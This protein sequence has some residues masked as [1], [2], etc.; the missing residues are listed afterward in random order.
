MSMIYY[1]DSNILFTLIIPY[2]MTQVN[3]IYI[4]IYIYIAETNISIGHLFSGLINWFY[5][6]TLVGLFNAENALFARNCKV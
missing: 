3:T 4:Y 6:S 5:M 1:T 2:V